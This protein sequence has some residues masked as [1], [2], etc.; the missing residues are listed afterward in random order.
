MRELL[1]SKL[2]A[3]P[4][5]IAMLTFA[6]VGNS[7]CRR[8]RTSI[9]LVTRRLCTT[10]ETLLAHPRAT[11]SLLRQRY[12]HGLEVA[13]ASSSRSRCS[14]RPTRACG[15][16]AWVS[17]LEGPQA[18]A[19]V[20]MLLELGNLVAV[21]DLAELMCIYLEYYSIY[22]TYHLLLATGEPSNVPSS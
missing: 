19:K 12:N 9:S 22:Q 14:R 17:R 16:R 6:I 3:C 18:V 20:K 13:T 8:C 21:S 11:V 4:S 7:I 5:I 10:L 15:I 2:I 1:K